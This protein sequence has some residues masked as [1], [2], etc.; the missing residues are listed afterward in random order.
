MVDHRDLDRTN[1]RWNN[2]RRATRSTNAANTRRQ[3]NNTSGF[4]GVYPHHKTGR[5]YAQIRKDGRGYYLGSFATPQAAHE[6][7]AAAARELF[8]EFARV[9]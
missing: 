2:L 3:R 9:E 8:G 6:A 4:K 5:W 7:Y 1:N